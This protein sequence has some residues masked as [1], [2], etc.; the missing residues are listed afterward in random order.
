M[1]GLRGSVLKRVHTLGSLG[2]LGHK[3][4]DMM[5]RGCLFVSLVFLEVC[6]SLY[7]IVDTFGTKCWVT[8]FGYNT[9]WVILLLILN[10]YEPNI[11]I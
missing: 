7:D 6:I 3:S 8:K 4:G 5:L 1:E 10:F 11:T 2:N 9:S